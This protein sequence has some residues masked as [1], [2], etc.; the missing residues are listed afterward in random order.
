M[1]EPELFPAT[2]EQP[3]QHWLK[4]ISTVGTVPQ[5]VSE[6]I[7]DE[8][9]DWMNWLINAVSVSKI[10]ADCALTAWLPHPSPKE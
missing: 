7:P 3:G 10:Y 1:I 5:W 9:A 2:D 4:R 8:P 6:Q